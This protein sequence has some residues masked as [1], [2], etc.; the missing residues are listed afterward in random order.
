MHSKFLKLLNCPIDA[1]V[2]CGQYEQSNLVKSNK[3][4]IDTSVMCG[5]FEHNN[6]VK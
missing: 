5:Q 2:M 3:R 1:P 4:R 6:C